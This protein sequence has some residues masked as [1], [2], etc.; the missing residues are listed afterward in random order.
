MSTSHHITS[1]HITF[2]H[3]S[4]PL[5]PTPSLGVVLYEIA[6]LTPPFAGQNLI[7]L[8]EAIR[9]AKYQ[10]LPSMFSDSLTRMVG[11]MLQKNYTKRPSIKQILSWFGAGYEKKLSEVS[12]QLV[13]GVAGS[14]LLLLT[15]K[16]SAHI[17]LL[18]QFGPSD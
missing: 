6:C 10:P 3:F 13:Y 11:M 16:L 14:P 17:A 8:A 5:V 4:N 7:A 18:Q 1:H 9:H 12:P 2:T 15:I